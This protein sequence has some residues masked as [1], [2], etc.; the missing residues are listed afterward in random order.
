MVLFTGSSSMSTYTFLDGPAFTMK[1]GE[2][3]AKIHFDGFSPKK[4]FL[5]GFI[6]TDGAKVKLWIQLHFQVLKDEIDGF[7]ITKGPHCH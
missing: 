1:K 2:R 7:L 5:V 3:Q 4:V 6:P